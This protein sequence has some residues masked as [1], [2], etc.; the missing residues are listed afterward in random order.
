MMRRTLCAWCL[1][2]HRCVYD[3]LADDYFCGEACRD[4]GRADP[5]TVA[6]RQVER[7]AR[8]RE[9]GEAKRRQF[10]QG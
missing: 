2:S 9:L 10:S 8:Q 7:V 3:I 1:E 5:T 4:A 6:R